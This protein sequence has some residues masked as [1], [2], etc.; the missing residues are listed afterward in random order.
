MQKKSLSRVK[1][2]NIHLKN[3]KTPWK[4]QPHDQH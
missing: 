2:K 3:F 1:Y 4:L